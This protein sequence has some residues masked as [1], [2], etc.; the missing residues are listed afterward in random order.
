M[1][2]RDYDG[3]VI[4]RH[5]TGD[6]ADRTSITPLN[7]ELI[8]T[9]DGPSPRVWA[10]GDTPIAGGYLVGP[11]GKCYVHQSANQD[12]GTFTAFPWNQQRTVT[13]EFT[14]STSTSNSEV[15]VEEDGEYNIEANLSLLFVNA[16]TFEIDIQR[17][18]GSSWN[19]LPGG[20]AIVSGAA[21]SSANLHAVVSVGL[22][23]TW[24]I[25]VLAFNFLF[26]T[27]NTTV[28]G[29]FGNLNITRIR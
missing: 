2:G 8:V 25:R 11:A 5:R 20:K 7:G 19:T 17:Y 21:S 4:H 24:K 29:T 27:G 9:Q 12:I 13:P 23:A 15:T 3:Q 6:S 22:L 1:G 28:Y 16:T 14:H 18:N 26:A 10:Q